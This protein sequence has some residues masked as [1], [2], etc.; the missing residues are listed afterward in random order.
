VIVIELEDFRR[1][2]NYI[3][4]FALI[5]GGGVIIPLSKSLPEW[6]VGMLLV[7]GIVLFYCIDKVLESD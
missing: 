7:G 1:L 5:F 4:I 2:I 3:K 6:M